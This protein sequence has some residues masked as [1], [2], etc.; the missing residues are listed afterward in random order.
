MV[1]GLDGGV[2][3]PGSP[4]LAVRNGQ[5]GDQVHAMG[6]IDAGLA[7]V[8]G[9]ELDR[10]LAGS[11]ARWLLVAPEQWMVVHAAGGFERSE[12]AVPEVE[13]LTGL[14]TAPSELYLRVGAAPGPA[15]PPGPRRRT[16]GPRDGTTC[17]RPATRRRSARRRTPCRRLRPGRIGTGRD[18]GETGPATQRG[19][20]TV[21][22][23]R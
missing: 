9:T 15:G 12:R 8:P 4:F 2:L 23:V 17:L 3:V 21:V 7:D 11:D 19:T 13:T 20:G 18:G 6:H 22:G 16:A 1:G 14:I 10:F 5:P